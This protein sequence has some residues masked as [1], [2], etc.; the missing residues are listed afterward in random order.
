MCQERKER[1]ERERKEREEQERIEAERKKREEQEKRVRVP[2]C[3][4]CMCMCVC[5]Y[6]C[7]YVCMCGCVCL[8]ACLCVI[9][10]CAEILRRVC[11]HIYPRQ[12]AEQTLYTL[13]VARFLAAFMPDTQRLITEATLESG[14]QTLVGSTCVHTTQSIAHTHTHRTHLPSTTQYTRTDDT[15]YI[16]HTARSLERFVNGQSSPPD[17]AI[18]LPVWDGV[19]RCQR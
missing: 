1:E 6:L 13:I 17:A 9:L 3:A 10:D 2:V 7:V 18:R 14:G 15:Q 8:C 11:A 12:P 5:V 19:R 4:C 16:L